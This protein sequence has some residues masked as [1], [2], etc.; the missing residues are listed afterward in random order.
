MKKCASVVTL[1]LTAPLL[2]GEGI[3]WRSSFDEALAEAVATGRPVMIDF[4]AKW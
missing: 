2:A 1:L 3:A 4:T